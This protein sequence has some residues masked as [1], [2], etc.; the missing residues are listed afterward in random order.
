[1]EIPSPYGSSESKGD[2]HTLH[3]E[4]SVPHPQAD[5]WAAIATP[6]GLPT[7]LAA[8]EP[9]EQREGGAITL[10][11]LNTDP[12]GKATVAPGQVTAWDPPRLVEYTVDIHGR[13][14]FELEPAPASVGGTLLHFTNE[15]TGAE[16][17]RLDCLAGWH[18]HFEYLLSALAGHP[19]DW[20]AWQPDRWRKLRTE[21]QRGRPPQ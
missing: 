20:S 15:L 14:R 4:L 5:V 12:E 19:A 10:R 21:Y 9:F 1:M 2:Q 18:H 13:I 8:A 3:Y 17:T 6:E 16:D 7:W 11:W